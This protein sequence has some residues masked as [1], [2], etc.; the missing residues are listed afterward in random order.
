MRDREREAARRAGLS[1]DMRGSDVYDRADRGWVTVPD[2]KAGRDATE[3]VRGSTTDL[4]YHHSRRSSGSAAC[5]AVTGLSFDPELLYIGAMFHDLGRTSNSVTAAAASS[6][7]AGEARRF[8]AGPR[9]AEDSIRRVWTAIACTPRR[10]P[11]VHGTRGRAGHRG[12]EYRRAGHGYHDISAADRAEI[13]PCTAGG[14]QAQH[15]AAFTEASRPS[16]NDVRQRQ[17]GRPA[18]IRPRLPT[19]QLRGHHR[20]LG[21]AE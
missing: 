11:G 3:L 10:V 20:E 8:P 5:R 1:R 15:P 4:V 16:R 7:S 12:V 2:T 9:R 17:G 19:R 6:D 21:L 13:T 14:V 18:A